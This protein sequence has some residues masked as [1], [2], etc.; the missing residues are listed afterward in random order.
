[1]TEWYFSVNRK[2]VAY[3]STERSGI[4]R[5]SVDRVRIGWHGA[6]NARTPHN[7][8]RQHWTHKWNTRQ[9][10]QFIASPTISYMMEIV[11]IIL[12]NDTLKSTLRTENAPNRK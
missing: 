3:W 6:Q 8:L 9:M 10:M 12:D 2:S 5:S 1:M 7:K 4:S 11:N